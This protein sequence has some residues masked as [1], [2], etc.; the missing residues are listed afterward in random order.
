[1]APNATIPI[2]PGGVLPNDNED[3]GAFQC[4]FFIGHACIFISPYLTVFAILVPL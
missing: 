1:M 4:V 3:Y 2:Q